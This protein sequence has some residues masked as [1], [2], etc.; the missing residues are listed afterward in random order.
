VPEDWPPS[1]WQALQPAA[2]GG[3]QPPG[4]P[5]G[6]ERFVEAAT[7][8]GLLP[9]LFE[10]D[11]LP[12]AVVAAL[13][14]RRVWARV[15]ERRA[16]SLREALCELPSLLDGEPF[17]VLKGCD[18][19]ERLYPRPGLRTMQDIDILVPRQRLAAV[20]DSLRRAGKSQLFPG[21][22]THRVPWFSESVFDLGDVTLEVHD[23]FLSRS[24]HSID[25]AALWARRVALELGA[26]AA[27]RLAEADALAY[28]ALSLAKDEFLARLIR[29]VDLWLMLRKNPESLPVAAERAREWRALHAFYGCLQQAQAVFPE[30]RELVG[31]VAVALLPATTRRFL[32]RYVLPRAAHP[33]TLAPRRRAL[34]LWR[35]LW[36]MDSMPHRIH[37]GIDY[38]RARAWGGWLGWR[39]RRT[40]AAHK[41]G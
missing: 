29:Y 27:S 30:L 14:R 8:E 1:L 25:Y 7:R 31:P 21:S 37:F 36:L 32:D 28:H 39:A 16:A 9:L 2:G 17:V 19:A 40:Q 5:D 38:C 6:A 23:S 15:F 24:R 13:E 4:D 10:Q 22:P 3:D 18:Y 35:K 41:T 33:T 26:G 12:A 34:Q 11:A 20:C